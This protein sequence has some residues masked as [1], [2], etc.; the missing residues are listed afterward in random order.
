MVGGCTSHQL[1]PLQFFWLV[2]HFVCCVPYCCFND[3]NIIYSV[4]IAVPTTTISKIGLRVAPTQKYRLRIEYIKT[5]TNLDGKYNCIHLN[6]G[7]TGIAELPKIWYNVNSS[8]CIAGKA[9]NG[10]KKKRKATI[11]TATTTKTHEYYELFSHKWGFPCNNPH[12]Y[13]SEYELEMCIGEYI[14]IWIL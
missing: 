8:K 10:E 6:I 12:S 14:Y 9:T 1:S 2:S 4:A 11:T 3:F 7:L 13:K 5:C